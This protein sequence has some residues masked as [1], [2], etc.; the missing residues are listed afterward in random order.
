[1]DCTLWYTCLNIWRFYGF[2]DRDLKPAKNGFRGWLRDKISRKSSLSNKIRKYCP[3]LPFFVLL[4][5]SL[6]HD[7]M[8]FRPLL[9][10]TV[11]IRIAIKMRIFIRLTTQL[12]EDIECFI[13][14][15]R[16]TQVHLCREIKMQLNVILTKINTNYLCHEILVKQGKT[17]MGKNFE[18]IYF[19]PI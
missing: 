3:K 18:G 17:F 2:R 11:T 16:N 9:F 13:K 19:H 1:M 4:N 14:T 6:S 8:R 10:I 12:D 7:I 5:N 15:Q